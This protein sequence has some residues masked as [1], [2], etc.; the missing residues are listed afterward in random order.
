MQ[1]HRGD[2]D[3]RIGKMHRTARQGWTRAQVTV[4]SAVVTGVLLA[5]ALPALAF[6]AQAGAAAAVDEVWRI[7]RDQDAPD[8]AGVPIQAGPVAYAPRVGEAP[9]LIVMVLD[10]QLIAYDGAGGKAWSVPVE[11]QAQQFIAVADVDRD[12]R[13]EL[14]VPLN[15][16]IM[17]V[18]DGGGVAW[19]RSLE[20]DPAGSA[21]CANLLGDERLEVV[22]AD[23][24]GGITCLDSNGRPQWRLLAESAVRVLDKDPFISKPNWNYERYRNRDAV[25][26]PAVGDVDGDGQAEVLL[27]TEP[28]YVYCL[29]GR[30]EWKWQF[31]AGGKCLGT[32]VIADLD[33]DGTAEI[34]VG[35]DDKRVYVLAGATGKVRA[36]IP[37][38]WGVG[39][40]IAAAD[41]DRDGIPEILFGDDRGYFYCCE[42]D[43]E[44]RWR[45]AFKADPPLTSEYGD[46]FLAPAAVADIDG[47]GV[48]ELVL[49]M[50][51]RGLLYVLSPDGRIERSCVLETG[52]KP[53]RLAESGLRVTPIVTDTDGDGRVEIIAATRLFTLACLRSTAKSDAAIAWAGPR[54]TPALTGCVLAQCGGPTIT[55]MPRARAAVAGDIRLTLDAASLVNGVVNA[56][57]RRPQEAAGV[58]LTSVRAASGLPELRVDQVI[59][60]D[61]HF[62]ISV[63]NA[64]D[65][66]ESLRCLLVSTE[67]GRVMADRSARVSLSPKAAREGV[68]AQTVAAAEEAIKQLRLEWPNAE[69]LAAARVAA[70][71]SWTGEPPAPAEWARR[72]VQAAAEVRALPGLVK[73]QRSAT[74]PLYLVTWT[75]NPWD[76]FTPGTAWPETD[77]AVPAQLEVSLYQGEYEAA[78]ANLLNVAAMP[79]Q[80]RVAVS[81]L[82]AADGS[83]LPAGQHVELRRTRMVPRH[84]GDMVG[85]ALPALD[86]AGVMSVPPMEAAQLWVTVNAV[87]AAPGIYSGEITITEMT[88]QS[89]AAKVPLR[90][91]VWPILL[92]KESPVRFCTWAYLDSSLFGDHIDAAMA[93]LIAHKNTVFTLN[94]NV[95]V[96]YDESGR[97]GQPDWGAMDQQLDRYAGHGVILALEPGVEY[98][99]QRQPSPE[100]TA[101]AFSGAVR[102]LAQHMA[103][104]GLGY[105]DWAIY[106]VD[107]PGLDHGPRITYLIDHARCIKQADP[108][109]RNYTDPV[110]P[111]SVEDLKRAAPYVD[112]WCPEQD[113]LWRI[114][115]P[116]PD[117]RADEKLAV[118][119]ADSPE[120][121]TYECFPR[122]KRT[123]P[124]GYYRN[125]AWF[126]WTRGLNGLGFWTYCTDPNDPWLPNRDEYVLV[127]PGRDGPIPSKR[128]EACRDGVEDYEALWLARQAANDAGLRGDA[129]AAT[130]RAEIDTLA[131]TVLQQRSVLPA[132]Q[133]ARRRLAEIT[134]EL[135]PG[136]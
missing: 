89:R 36:A 50:S 136:E 10:Q 107:E 1:R 2:D 109:V 64:A 82:A 128:W 118:L 17:C 74:G 49:G 62:G 134:I 117:M 123:S 58:L 85:D 4:V 40:S 81:D 83:T 126:A 8:G 68:H 72:D 14:V 103:D 3:T 70:L 121:W 37:T 21:V 90:V 31:R 111:M 54:G 79:L 5:I 53:A 34:I 88:P 45:V 57:V 13:N 32:P 15:D 27:A 77:A 101:T 33:K 98:T 19:R 112:I 26:P 100:A 38:A 55:E 120:V 71:G 51:G 76:L 12:G 11:G 130:A 43:G 115:G 93:D 105:N 28:G 66:P 35:S 42:P 59:T 56:Q 29:S 61:D 48:L 132:I 16:G 96:P 47:D 7:E 129:R 22:V 24:D 41:L 9:R 69:A 133:A 124:L 97:V 60:Q 67:D 95:S 127:Y 114:W 119:R 18:R 106:V 92:P 73:R 116:T 65:W 63:P 84:A 102:L 80:V 30:G 113:S 46:R 110:V 99:G 6:G 52:Q 104:K 122:V 23:G 125:Q 20:A 94:A 131:E 108:R 25:V 86:E 91:K 39:P 44:Q 87:G 75:A 135:T 78:A